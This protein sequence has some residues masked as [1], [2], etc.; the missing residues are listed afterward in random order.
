VLA[1]VASAASSPI[2]V[3]VGENVQFIS[4]FQVNVPVTIS[5]TAGSGY[6]LSVSVVEPEGFQFTMFGG[7]NASG[8]CTGQQ[9]KLA[10]PAYP[11]TPFPGFGWQLGDAVATVDA[12]QF[13]PFACDGGTKA[14]H[15]VA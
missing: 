5:C 15:I 1:N 2:S 13:Q 6:N 3:R 4:P 10:V 12:C 7:G 14:V 11:F 8:Q 9:Q